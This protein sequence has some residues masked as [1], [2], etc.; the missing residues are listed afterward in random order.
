MSNVIELLWNV[1]W[2]HWV[3]G[4]CR[5]LRS[6][7]E[8]YGSVMGHCMGRYRMLQKPCKYWKYRFCLL[9]IKF[10]ILFVTKMWA[11]LKWACQI[12]KWA[13]HQILMH[14]DRLTNHPSNNSSDMVIF[15]FSKMAAGL[16]LEFSNSRN[17][18]SCP[19]CFDA[20]GWAA[21]MA[22]GL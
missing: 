20:V 19:Q 17:L 12:R 14:T 4:R 7:V 10:L 2:S 1:I 18:T 22:S 8:R 11:W 5:A 15:R 6:I 16:H 9:L 3:R 21:G 13:R